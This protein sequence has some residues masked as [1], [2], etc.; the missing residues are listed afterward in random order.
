MESSPGYLGESGIVAARIAS[1][2]PDARLVFLVR[3]PIDP[4]ISCYRFYQSR[5][6]LPRDMSFDSFVHACLDFEAGR[7]NTSA[8][9][10]LPWHLNALS[11]GRY[12]LHIST[13]RRF[14]PGPQIL[15][16]G[17]DELAQS[18]ARTMGKVCAFA[19]MSSG[20]YDSYALN[21][22]NVTFYGSNRRL[23]RIAITVNDR[24]TTF[25]RRHPHLKQR[26]VRTYKS[27]NSAK[28]PIV[29]PAPATQACL[30]EYYTATYDFLEQELGH[31]PSAIGTKM[32]T[33][34]L[35]DD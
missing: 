24:L 21:E 35:S 27:L 7:E 20:F 11:R 17:F 33:G 32:S 14:L 15:L 31:A 1:V 4:L 12:E 3:D 16:L 22:E 9:G 26:L 25:W 34:G 28:P 10:I 8:Q 2:V 30:K 18:P 6:H 23:H 5:L 13:F 19:D 29:T